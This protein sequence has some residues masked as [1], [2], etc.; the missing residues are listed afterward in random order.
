MM[1]LGS[2]RIYNSN[3]IVEARKKVK[4][5]SLRLGCSEVMAT[6]LE[7]VISE[8]CRA[9]VTDGHVNV[10]E[11]SMG[12]VDGKFGVQLLVS[13]VMKAIHLGFAEA[14]FDIF[15]V[16][17]QADG[18]FKVRMV[19]FFK[20][21]D[22]VVQQKKIDQIRSDI[23]TPSREELMNAIT[24]KN[25]ELASSKQ[26]LQSV[27]ENI[28]SVVYAKDLDGRYTYM[29]NQWEKVME[30]NRD[31]AFGKCDT[32]LFQREIGEKF[33]ENDIDVMLS[34]EVKTTEEQFRNKKDEELIFLSTKV[35][36]VQDDKIIGLCGISTDI[37]DRKNMEKQ[38]RMTHL[39]MLSEKDKADMLIKNIL[40]SQV[41]EEL[42]A[43]GKTN[44]ISFEK[45]AVMFSDL[46]GFTRIS[47]QMTAKELI[48]EL[49]DIFSAY[50]DVIE[51]NHCERIKTIGD[52]Y[53][54]VSGLP[55]QNDQ[56]ADN[57]VKSAVEVLSFLKARTKISEYPWAATIGI[58]SGEVVGGV[59]GVKKYI[60][61]IFGTTV[62]MASRL[63]SAS[64]IYKLD[65]LISGTVFN[66]IKNPGIFCIREIDSVR[67]KG[68]ERV[69][70]LYEV[71]DC[72]EETLREKKKEMMCVFS[73]GIEAYKLGKFVDALEKFKLCQ[74]RC[75]EDTVPPVY[76]KRC[77]TL[78]RMPLSP[79]WAGVSGI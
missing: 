59:V 22:A 20:T 37:T 36:M 35:P 69:I 23:A 3:S 46:V 42:K 28:Q 45:A 77:S 5:V 38:M 76:I 43:T 34:M 44:P 11:A 15:E 60:Y 6:R 48:D 13:N 78:M 61:D 79:D 8:V 49:N 17:S 64:K 40:P 55:I 18:T 52:A 19:I 33:Q 26:F 9:C 47:S 57:I 62:N 32:E 65:I 74:E 67:V 12:E 30:H 24:H 21:I 2:V 56:Y 75:P 41:A 4:R 53:M 14:F 31:E 68:D 71:F 10:M 70:T 7:A 39:Q 27:L 66:D 63:Q 50:D 73:E 16:E 51:S 29:N 58:D 72:D 1:N 54:A 25:E